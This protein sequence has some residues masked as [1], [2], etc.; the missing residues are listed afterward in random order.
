MYNAFTEG[1]YP[2]TYVTLPSHELK[3][4]TTISINS[5][6]T[7]LNDTEISKWLNTTLYVS[8]CSG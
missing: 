1:F 6:S 7:V 3:G 5:T 2:Y 8:S 4:S